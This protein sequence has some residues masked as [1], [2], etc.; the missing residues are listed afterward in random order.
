MLA[1]IL[2]CIV[3]YV[4]VYMKTTI[5]TYWTWCAYSDISM[6]VLANYKN[7]NNMSDTTKN[8][9]RNVWA[10]CLKWKEC[11]EKVITLHKT[12]NV[13]MNQEVVCNNFS[14][15]SLHIC[16]ESGTLGVHLHIRRT[17]QISHLD[18]IMICHKMVY[19]GQINISNSFVI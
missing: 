1:R 11:H 19:N 5:H 4:H 17:K 14:S 7:N 9:I 18:L 16:S 3:Q 6:R 2:S 15:T 13:M 8:I 10:L 12:A